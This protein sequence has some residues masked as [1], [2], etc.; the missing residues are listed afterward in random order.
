MGRRGNG[1]G[2]IYKRKSG[3]W[4]AQAY[5]TLQN[6]S[7]KRVGITAK[8][9][10]EVK[11]KLRNLMEQENR[12]VPYAEKNWTVGSYL[13]YWLDNVQAKKIR[14]TTM[15]SYKT[16]VR[17]HIKPAMGG[18]KLKELNPYDVR[19]ALEIMEK[20]GC[21]NQTRVKCMKV[22]SACLNNAMREELIFRNVALIV[23]KPA[24]RPKQTLIW[25]TEQ[26][27]AF[28]QTVKEHPQYLAFLL[29]LTYGMRRGEVLGLRYSDIDFENNLIHVRQQVGRVDGSIKAWELKTDSSRRALP[30]VYF[31]HDAIVRHAKIKGIEMPPFSTVSEPSLQ[32]TIIRS[33]AGTP[34]EPRNLTRCFDS[35]TAKAGLPRIKIHAMRHIAATI[36]KDLGVPLKDIQLILGHANISTTIKVYQHGTLETQRMAISAIENR[37]HGIAKNP[38]DTFDNFQQISS[39]IFDKI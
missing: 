15:A 12:N 25:T 35:L 20:Q 1:E 38:T 24:Y 18:R 27:S 26:S 4:T 31:I 8:S 7:R 28:I 33:K 23:E 5:V 13:D 29:F 37:L 21:S 32:D 3:S 34:L 11:K 9:N 30:L 10:E 6:G 14:E 17:C 16:M 22:L 19:H 36:L 2:S 39:G